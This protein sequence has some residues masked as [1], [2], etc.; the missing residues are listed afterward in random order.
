MLHHYF[1]KP[2]QKSS[3]PFSITALYILMISC[4]F[5]IT[6]WLTDN[7][8]IIL[9]NWLPLME[10]YFLKRKVILHRLPLNS[11]VWSSRLEITIQ[12]RKS[13]RNYST[14]QMKIWPEIK[15]SNFLGL[16]NVNYLQ[17]F[18]PHVAIHTNQLPKLLKKDTPSWSITQ[19]IA[20]QCL[21]RDWS[22][23]TN[24]KDS[25]NQSKNT[26]SVMNSEVLSY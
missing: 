21:K 2:W 6:M 9:S 17:D 15:Y 4:F 1:K 23:S 26:P 11:L 5:Q 25:F 18:L 10:S 13:L 12:V 19:I 14:F 20:V 8:L 16:W 7:S 3:I 24:F 22:E